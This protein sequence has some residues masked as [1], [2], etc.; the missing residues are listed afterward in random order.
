MRSVLWGTLVAV[1]V[2]VA[3]SS[4]HPPAPVLGSYG[5]VP[6]F[7]LTDQAGEP[8]QR[9]NLQGKVWV[10]DFIFTSCG[11]SCP[12]MTAQMATLARELPPT[13]ELVSV[14]V[15][16]QR[17]T[18]PVLAQYAQAHGA[19]PDRWHFLTGPPE[20]IQRLALEGFRF[21][22]ASG[23]EEPEPITHSVR[24]ALV[25]RQGVVR[26]TYDGT[27]SK[28]LERLVRDARYL[29]GQY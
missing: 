7:H 20:A 9:G 1:M 27:D 29:E 10:A 25:D 8:F 15:D 2:G 19:Q 11:G 17:D 18:P 12:Q 24:F 26:G 21:S 6:E 23:G 22:F 28:A 5:Q 16:P 3:A 4:F 13:V 14:T